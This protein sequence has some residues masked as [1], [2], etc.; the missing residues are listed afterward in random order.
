MGRDADLAA[1]EAQSMAIADQ[2]RA[3]IREAQRLR[4]SR[5]RADG[6]LRPSTRSES[7]AA[8]LR[9]MQLAWEKRGRPWDEQAALRML[10]ELEQ[11]GETRAYGPGGSMYR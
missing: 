2:A 11:R 6:D 4:A 7:R 1:I 3:W 9:A 10:A 5:G 8:R